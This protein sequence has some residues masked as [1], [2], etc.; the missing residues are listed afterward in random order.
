[1][2]Y[3]E[4]LTL[5]EGTFVQGMTITFLSRIFQVPS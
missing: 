2:G 3:I 5:G 4:Q 1:M